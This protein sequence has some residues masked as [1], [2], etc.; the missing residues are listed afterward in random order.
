MHTILGAGGPTAN[1]LTKTL[2]DNN[3]VVRLVSRRPSKIK[4]ANVSWRK[5]DLLVYSEILEASKGSTVIYMC[6]GLVYDKEIWKVQWPVII[7]NLIDVSKELQCRL[8]FFDNVYMYGLV[9]GPMTEETPYN[10]G[11]VKGEVRARVATQLMEEVKAGNIRASIARAADFYGTDSMNSFLDMMVLDKFA[12]KQRAQWIGKA[13]TLHNFTFIPD[14]GTSL[15][16]LGQ[17]PGTDNQIWHL[18]T[19]PPLRGIEFIQM[20]AAVYGVP[21]KFFGISKFMLQLIGLFNKAVAG[22]V[23]MYYQYDHDY[24]FD[25]SKFENALQI[26]PTPYLEG[27][28]M[29]SETLYKKQ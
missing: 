20:A 6:A 15:Y 18:P 29:M 4:A 27:I 2:M 5:A 3:E 25:S 26:K 9:N 14:T 16:R 19:A 24:I 23:E 11:S 8:I 22:T 13:S 10:P 21:P 1:A 7:Q 28:R 17:D 12:K